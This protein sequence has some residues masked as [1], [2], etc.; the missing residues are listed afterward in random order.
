MINKK[1]GCFINGNIDIPV[2]ITDVTANCEDITRTVCGPVKPKLPPIE[3]KTQE[4]ETKAKPS[5]TGNAF[6][7]MFK[8]NMKE[9]SDQGFEKD[10]DSGFMDSDDEALG[11]R[12]KPAVERDTLENLDERV[13]K[14][15]VGQAQIGKSE[16]RYNEAQ[17]DDAMHYQP[18]IKTTS[19]NHQDRHMS[20]KKHRSKHDRPPKVDDKPKEDDFI[21]DNFDRKRDKYIHEEK[22]R[23]ELERKNKKKVEEKDLDNIFSRHKIKNQGASRNAKKSGAKMRLVPVR[24]IG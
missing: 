21:F 6:M 1:E 11:K 3:Q 9:E 17:L 22:L 12:D 2:M 10:S 16:L 23:E 14:V 4:K 18:K 19:T 15:I 8:Q 20:K 5:G 7:D 13:K 24:P